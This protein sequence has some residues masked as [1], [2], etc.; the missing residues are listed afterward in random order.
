MTTDPAEAI[1]EFIA[2]G[3]SLRTP[4]LLFSRKRCIYTPFH[5][6]NDYAVR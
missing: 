1:G 4:V 3:A 5:A 6:N 2:V